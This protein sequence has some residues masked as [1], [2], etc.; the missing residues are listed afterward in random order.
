MEAI[1]TVIKQMKTNTCQRNPGTTGTI[2][3]KST[4]IQKP[5]LAMEECQEKP[6]VRVDNIQNAGDTTP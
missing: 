6:L 4:D 3:S 1:T 5:P 2:N